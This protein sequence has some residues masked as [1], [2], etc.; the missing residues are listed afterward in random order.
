MLHISRRDVLRD[1]NSAF[2]FINLQKIFPAFVAINFANGLRIAASGI[3]TF[4]T[5]AIV[6]RY[7]SIYL[8]QT[9]NYIPRETQTRYR[10][11]KRARDAMYAL[12]S[13]ISLIETY[14]IRSD[15]FLYE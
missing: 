7:R 5:L 13:V 11:Y 12:I 6:G 8:T 9:L 3:S 4:V 10:N 14:F 15:L 1:G 2:D